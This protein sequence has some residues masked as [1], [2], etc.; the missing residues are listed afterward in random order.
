MIFKRYIW[1]I[2]LWSIFQT[3]LAQDQRLSLSKEAAE[4]LCE[5]PLK[6]LQKEYPNKLNQVLAEAEDIGTPQALHPAFYGCFDWHSSVHGH[7]MLVRLLR[8]FPDL[9][10][11][12]AIKDILKQHLTK[13]HI[14]GELAYF[15]RPS[16]KSFE[17]TYGWAWLLK[18][19]E[20]LFRWEDALA[21]ELR[22]NLHPLTQLVTE[23]FIDFLPR[24]QYPIRTGEHPNTA[25]GLSLAYDYALTVGDT[26]LIEMIEKRSRDFFLNDVNCPINWEPG[27]Y[28]FLSPCLQEADLMSRV[29]DQDE[30]KAWLDKFL[31]QLAD[32]DF[33]MEYAVVSDRTD[34]KLVH[35]DGTNFCRAWS[36][37]AIA[38]ALPEYSH[39][40]A[41]ANDH[42][43]AS[44]ASIADGSYEGEHWLAS[45]AILSMMR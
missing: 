28:D 11:S 27:G 3:A 36:L 29:L 15:L 43:N 42:I 44:V 10:H 22:A 13:E 23:R 20:E 32:K 30:F 1:L 38:A 26:I 21:V 2:G 35:L 37:Y 19:D 12:P 40:I 17:R 9:K 24:L 33:K 5:L 8:A 39:L 25:F 41:L 4:H 18:L 14:E 45:F 7:W 34:G 6:C 31:P 16:E